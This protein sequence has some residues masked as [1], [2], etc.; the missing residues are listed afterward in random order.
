MTLA[1]IAA[2]CPQRFHWRSFR[3][4]AIVHRMS[5]AATTTAEV[6]HWTAHQLVITIAV[7]CES[8]MSRFHNTAAIASFTNASAMGGFQM[9]ELSVAS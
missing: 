3:G 7:A 4:T 8:V 5:G 2:I 9:V 1:T 6:W